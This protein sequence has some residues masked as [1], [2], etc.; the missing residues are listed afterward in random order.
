MPVLVGDALVARV[1]PGRE[2]EVLVACSLHLEPG[3]RPEAVGP[4]IAAALA[5]A[6]RWVAATTVVLERVDPDAARRPLEAA[7]EAAGLR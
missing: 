3:A 6:A 1:D 5:E 7:L 2:G 4:G